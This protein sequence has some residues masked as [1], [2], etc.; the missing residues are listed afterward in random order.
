L[1]EVFGDLSF[2]EYVLSFAYMFAKLDRGS[3]NTSST[4]TPSSTCG[5]STNGVLNGGDG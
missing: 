5:A 3:I 2:H 1:S 4:E